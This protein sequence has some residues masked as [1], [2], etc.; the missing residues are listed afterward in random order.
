MNRS[1]PLVTRRLSSSSL[2]QPRSFLTPPYPC[3][4]LPRL[5]GSNMVA[6]WRRKTELVRPRKPISKLPIHGAGQ[7]SKH[8]RGVVCVMA[9]RARMPVYNFRGGAVHSFSHR[10]AGCNTA[11]C[12]GPPTPEFPFGLSATTIRREP[13][14][15]PPRGLIHRYD[16]VGWGAGMNS[17]FV[18]SEFVTVLC[19]EA[20]S[21]SGSGLG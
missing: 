20:G 4:C 2:G 1:L 16:S 3:C 12:C 21:S 11:R 10:S 18:N 13:S 15:Y 19:T 8:G 7:L 6:H 14:G 5:L 17:P 9:S